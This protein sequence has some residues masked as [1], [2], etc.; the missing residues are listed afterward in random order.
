MRHV[1]SM[2]VFKDAQG[3]GAA[4]AGLLLRADSSGS[5]CGALRAFN[6]C[7]SQGIGPGQQAFVPGDCPVLSAEPR[8]CFP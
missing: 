2:E 6:E 3:T 4:S 8:K 1:G 5:K 7:G